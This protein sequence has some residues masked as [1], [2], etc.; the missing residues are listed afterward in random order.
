MIEYEQVATAYGYA[1]E[2]TK[3]LITLSTG[4][5]AITIALRKTSWGARPVGLFCLLSQHGSSFCSP[6][7]SAWSYWE[8]SQL[9]W[10]L[11]H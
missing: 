8:D 1:S 4:I 6:L 3:Q 9:A 2:K 11:N 5:I 7:F 10:W